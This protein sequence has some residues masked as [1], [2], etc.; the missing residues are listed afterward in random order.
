MVII[1]CGYAAILLK[2]LNNRNDTYEV[3][4]SISFYNERIKRLGIYLFCIDDLFTL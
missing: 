1:W 4:R 2:Q 3:R